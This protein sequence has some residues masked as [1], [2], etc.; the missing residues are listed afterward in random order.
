MGD[1][2]N[3]PNR[4]A[5]GEGE[6]FSR[7][8]RSV[9]AREGRHPGVVRQLQALPVAGDE[10]QPEM[11]LVNVLATIRDHGT[12]PRRSITPTGEVA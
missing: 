9:V 2:L 8:L 4:K 11:V 3:L 5:G 7:R 1:K 10:T 12:S 6:G